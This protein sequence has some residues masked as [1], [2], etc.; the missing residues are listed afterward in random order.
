MAAPTSLRAAMLQKD[1]TINADNSRSCNHC[2]TTFSA[3]S[4]SGP[5]RKHMQSAH[6]ER[7]LELAALHKLLH[8]RTSTER[9]DA[10]S[11]VSSAKSPAA[12]AASVVTT[13][14]SDSSSSSSKKQRTVSDMLKPKRQLLLEALARAF[15]ANSWAHEAVE[16]LEVRQLLQLLGFPGALPSRASIRATIAQ[17]SMSTRAEVAERLR[18]AIVTVGADGWTNVKRQKIT[19]IVPMVNGVAYYWCSITNTGE[20]TAEWL[21]SQLLPVIRELIADCGARVVG[22]VV[23]NEAVNGAAHRL[24]LPDLPFLLHIPCAAHTIQLIVRSCLAL[25]HFSLIVQQFVD[26]VRHFDAKQHRIALRRQQEQHE[27]KQL[28]VQKPCDTRWSSLL[29]SAE[30]MLLL[31]REVKHVCLDTLPSLTAEFWPKLREL[32]TFLKP[33]QV[34]TDRIQRDCATL[35]T[36]YEQFCMLRQHAERHEWARACID[37]RW[38][39]RVHVNAVTASAMLS[40][41]EP[42]GL[43]AQAAQQFIITFGAAYI[44]HYKLLPLEQRQIADT[45]MMQLADFNGREGVFQQLQQQVETMKRV[46]AATAASSAGPAPWSP[47]KVWLLYPGVALGIVAVA[48]LSMSAS[49]A[50][51]ERTFSAQGRLHT[52][53]R[54]LLDSDSVEAEMMQK[55][56]SRALRSDIPQLF[57]SVIDMDEAVDK[58]DEDA[59]TVVPVAIED[60]ELDERMELLE[61]DEVME[62]EPAAAAAAAQPTSAQRRALRRQPSVTFS[63]MSEFL[64]WFIDKHKLTAGSTITCDVESALIALSN[65]LSDTPGARTL[66]QRLQAALA[67]LRS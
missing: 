15:A 39:K 14:S 26:L 24:L 50:A 35:Y 66:K 23:D 33:F 22:C 10:V 30:R 49:E 29:M 17:V 45:L 63:S 12:A 53:A 44:W 67:A 58:F 36:V 1:I 47:R 37:D 3:K 16:S 41:V 2:S 43:D 4:D 7:E 6:K 59:A 28:V 51:V 34:A 64:S 19:N 56:N 31:E 42:V 61:E 65:R 9:D 48:L 20:N 25:P 55:F 60:G 54:N 8:A 38:E 57:G 11:V 52:K 5:W 21:A 27:V 46:A 13:S 62:E 40:F 32:V 18:G